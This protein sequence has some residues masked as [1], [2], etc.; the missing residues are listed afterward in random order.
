M[1]KSEISG[2]DMKKSKRIAVLCSAA[3]AA[4]LTVCGCGDSSPRQVEFSPMVRE[5]APFVLGVNL[6][7]EQAFKIVD[8]YVA[9]A[10]PFLKDNPDAVREIQ[11]E[12]AAYK[13]D[14]FKDASEDFRKFIEDS[15][16]REA[17][18]RWATLS[19][20]GDAGN[21]FCANPQLGG[22]SWA[23]AVDADIKRVIA[24]IKKNEAEGGKRITTF[25]EVEIEG[26]QV[27]HVIPKESTDVRD[28]AKF[29]LD[30]H[31]A[32]L[33]D[34][35]VLMAMSRE[36][37]AKQIRL[38]RK[39]EGRG[40][41]LG[42][43]AAADGEFLHLRLSGIGDMIRKNVKDGDLSGITT[44]VPNGTE[45]VKG[46]KNLDLDVNMAPDGMPSQ[47]IVL[48]AASAEDAE[49]IR[50]C[51]IGLLAM[52][53]LGIS[54]N[55][56]VP[57]EVK[58]YIGAVKIEGTAN[59]V[60][61]RNTDVLAVMAGALFPAISAAMHT[62]NASAMALRGRNLFVGLVQANVDRE[63]CG[64]GNVWPRTCVADGA[65]ANDIA[66]KAYG[67][68]TGY[69]ADLFDIANYGKPEW[70]PY[71]NVDVSVLG[72]DVVKGGTVNLGGIEWCV[73]ANVADE[74]PDCIPVLVSANF[75]P[76]FLLRKWDGV[77]DAMKQLPIGP[78]SG[79]AKSMLGDRGIVVI[80]KG[81]SA[82][83]IKKRHLNYSTIYSRQE[84]DTTNSAHPLMYLMPNGL[85]EP[86][87]GK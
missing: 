63:G 57:K 52:A 31:V 50:T 35:L 3:L 12:V 72:K 53:K 76:E 21:V 46:L 84:F 10:M 47:S 17:K 49:Q 67:S 83:F 5:G 51:L 29:N 27:W 23:V 55:P 22:I 79:A 14:V 75:N 11:D 60:E 77:T 80:S 62:A 38:Y 16:L 61:V 70:A 48:E 87:G 8:S 82:Q 19:C 25:E 44:V 86:T 73:A 6:D 26:E 54:R 9:K 33:D 58:Q 81:G 28:F 13:H 74:M 41:A 40:G 42:G 59:K 65:N 64:L 32:S 15:G 4:A 66:G 1:K 24:A 2:N 69:F 18:F 39:G 78:D 45:I 68:A 34:R 20:E 36:T 30:P 56:D 85:A 71:V 43:F 37:M 7:K